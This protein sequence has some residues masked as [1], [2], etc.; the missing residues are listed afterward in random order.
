MSSAHRWIR[1]RLQD[2]LP[3]HLMDLP[4][5]VHVV[6]HIQQG[7]EPAHGSVTRFT[8]GLSRADSSVAPGEPDAV[9]LQQSEEAAG[10]EETQA[11]ADPA[12]QVK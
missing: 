9:V 3:E 5:A 10:V 1:L 7:E 4:G 8:K 12:G 11:L 6:G 2:Q